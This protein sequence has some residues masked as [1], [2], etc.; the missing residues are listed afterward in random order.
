[1][2]EMS[3]WFVVIYV[4]E[5]RQINLNLN[6][7]SCDDSLSA[8]TAVSWA[9]AARLGGRLACRTLVLCGTAY[10]HGAHRGRLAW[11]VIRGVPAT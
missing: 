10:R 3:S 4:I 2:I 11:L 7:N 5:L 1:M 8:S 6:F 9:G